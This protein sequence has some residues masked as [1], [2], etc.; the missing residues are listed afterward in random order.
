[1]AFMSLA[2]TLSGPEDLVITSSKDPII[3]NATTQMCSF[4]VANRKTG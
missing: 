4:T 3:I 2:E 1:M